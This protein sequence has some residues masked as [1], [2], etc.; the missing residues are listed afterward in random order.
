MNTELAILTIRSRM[1]NMGYQEQDYSLCQKHIV[2]PGSG[3]VDIE[4]YNEFYFLEHEPEDVNIKS[5]FGLY[6]LSFAKCNELSYEHRGFISIH[7]YSA[8]MRHVR[9]IQVVLKHILN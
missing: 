1:Q 8:A 3:H 4:A 7:N 2:V 6:D 9:F 5:D